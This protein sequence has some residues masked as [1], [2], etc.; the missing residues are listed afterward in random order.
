MTSV[1]G[2]RRDV[3]HQFI[4]PVSC[5]R[6]GGRG[7]RAQVWAERDEGGLLRVR[8]I[9]CGWPRAGDWGRRHW[10]QSELAVATA[11]RRCGLRWREI[12]AALGRSHDAIAKAL[13]RRGLVRSGGR[14][15]RWTAEE[16]AA[17]LHGVRVGKTRVALAAELGRTI[18]AVK[19]RSSRLRPTRQ[20]RRPWTSVELLRLRHL[21]AAG[22]TAT[23]IAAVMR[24]PVSGVRWHLK[25]AGMSLRRRRLPRTAIVARAEQAARLVGL[26]WPIKAVA[27]RL[28]ISERSVYRDLKIAAAHHQDGANAAH[29]TH[30][31]ATMRSGA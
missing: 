17:L 13:V 16:D 15:R 11:L 8:C 28:G 29:E 31:C 30:D 2:W 20:R 14:W 10:T 19:R 7:G 27:R 22:F 5:A 6:C 26:G 25:N 1:T 21:A 3:P 4:V 23:R 9:V 12:A 18:A 24:R